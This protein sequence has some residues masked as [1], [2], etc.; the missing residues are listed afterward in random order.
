MTG[1]RT[2]TWTPVSKVIQRHMALHTTSF[3]LIEQHL[4]S[5]DVG[6]YL[7]V[8]GHYVTGI[9]YKINSDISRTGLHLSLKSCNEYLRETFGSGVGPW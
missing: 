1:G 5:L 3:L 6:L 2:D 7:Y 9:S 8:Q 4:W